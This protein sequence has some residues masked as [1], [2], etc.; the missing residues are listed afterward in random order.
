MK[1]KVHS[2]E[3]K[4]GENVEQ[5]EK[6]AG[7]EAL[8]GSRFMNLTTFRKNGTAVKTA[9]WFSEVGG[10][11]YAYTGWYTG[12]VKRI[13]DDSRAL[14]S[15]CDIRGRPR[16]PEVAG[17]ARLLAPAESPV[18]RESLNNKY[19]LQKR[20]FGRIQRFIGRGKGVYLQISPPHEENKT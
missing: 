10:Q 4:V 3:R 12:K 6:A 18:A 17:V 15:L 8:R 1:E 9:L 2:P 16:G 14:V 7:F 13:R 20:A 19:G 5:K 11:L